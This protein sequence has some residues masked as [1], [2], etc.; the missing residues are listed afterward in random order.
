MS[1][2]ETVLLVSVSSACLRVANA[3]PGGFWGVGGG[4]AR[5]H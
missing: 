3:L 5:G 2:G 4:E 1:S